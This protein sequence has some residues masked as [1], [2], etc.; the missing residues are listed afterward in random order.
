MWEYAGQYAGQYTEPKKTE[1]F[2]IFSNFLDIPFLPFL[3]DFSS[4]I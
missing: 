4:K 1:T 2:S 3:D